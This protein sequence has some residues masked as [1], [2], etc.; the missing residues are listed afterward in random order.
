MIVVTS[1]RSSPLAPIG[2][3]TSRMMVASAAGMVM[4]H[5]VSPSAVTVSSQISSPSTNHDATKSSVAW[6]SS[7]TVPTAV[8]AW[9]RASSAPF[10]G[11]RMLASGLLLNFVT[12]AS[13][14]AVASAHAS[15]KTPQF[16]PPNGRR[17]RNSLSPSINA[18]LAGPNCTVQEHRP[19]PQ[20]CKLIHVDQ[21]Q[22]LG[23]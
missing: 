20:L 21:R 13:W 11:V 2:S 4:S 10:D 3:C 6:S 14:H 19:D 18:P 5:C 23:S 22:F 17:I 12:P 8:K 7:S 1:I 16:T 9:P 15:A